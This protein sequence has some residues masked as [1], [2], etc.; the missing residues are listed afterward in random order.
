MTQEQNISLPEAV[1]VEVAR[2]REIMAETKRLLPNS[3][4][5]WVFYEAAIAEAELAVREQ[6]AVT[7]VRILPELKGM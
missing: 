4:V 6:D 2:L 5:S 1:Q 7:L 3:Q